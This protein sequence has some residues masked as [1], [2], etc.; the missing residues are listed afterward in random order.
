MQV[1]APFTT[2][3]VENIN[4]LQAHLG[5]MTCMGDKGCKRTID[6]GTLKATEE[7]LICPCGK[8]KQYWIPQGFDTKELLDMQIE[9]ENKFKNEAK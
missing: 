5:L 6:N 2:E 9:F 8:Y 3:Q 1:K 4:K 7:F